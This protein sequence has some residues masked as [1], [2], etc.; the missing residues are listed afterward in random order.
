MLIY[1]SGDPHKKKNEHTLHCVLLAVLLN[2][3][4]STPLLAGFER[5][6]A[7]RAFPMARH[8]QNH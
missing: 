5:V 6:Q 8:P 2:L 3:V 1:Q 4:N 7:V